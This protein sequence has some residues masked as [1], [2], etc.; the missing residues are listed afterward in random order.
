MR[1]VEVVLLTRLE[2]AFCD[3][4]KAMLERLSSE[5]P[6]K[7]RFVSFDSAEGED[8]AIRHGLLFPPGILLDD[9]PFSHGRPSERKLR[10]QLQLL[11]GIA[12]D[13]DQ[14]AISPT[15]GTPQLDD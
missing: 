12:G 15:S 3:D 6:L 9:K 10:R 4:A 8:L 5:I 13:I 2:C 7:L 14:P 11:S 1:T